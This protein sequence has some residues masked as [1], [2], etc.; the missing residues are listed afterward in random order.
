[1]L[2]LNKLLSSVCWLL[3]SE[4]PADDVAAESNMDMRLVLLYW[5]AAVELLDAPP[6]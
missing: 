3:D 2:L 5:L 6:E 4:L 1:L